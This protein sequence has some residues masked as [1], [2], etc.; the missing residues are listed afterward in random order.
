METL[1]ATP[2]GGTIMGEGRAFEVC[3]TLFSGLTITQTLSLR[4]LKIVDDDDDD[5]SSLRV[6]LADTT[7]PARN[8][9]DFRQELGF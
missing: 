6:A 7:A 9:E 8:Y 4:D 5:L 3:T 2:A 1:E